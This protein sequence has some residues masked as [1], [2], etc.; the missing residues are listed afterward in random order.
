MRCGEGDE[1]GV[2]DVVVE[3]KRCKQSA[4]ESGG[5]GAFQTRLFPSGFVYDSCR[6]LPS[7]ASCAFLPSSRDYQA[8]R[9]APS[10]FALSP[11][12][13]IN[14]A[15]LPS[16]IVHEIH[17]DTVEASRAVRLTTLRAASPEPSSP[18]PQN[19]HV[20]RS[21]PRYTGSLGQNLFL[22]CSNMHCER[23][24]LLDRNR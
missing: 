17:H 5:D 13:N 9:C 10:S 14:T 22:S 18:R 7:T 4:L 6:L 11:L 23:G 2:G 1:G 12:S 15:L 24:T 8:P 19:N 20:Y 16:E 3:W 21:Q